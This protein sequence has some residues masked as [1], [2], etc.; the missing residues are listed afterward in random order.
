M[1]HAVT[2]KAPPPV[3][4]ESTWDA[5]LSVGFVMGDL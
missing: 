5:A 2:G 3:M 1:D 4:L